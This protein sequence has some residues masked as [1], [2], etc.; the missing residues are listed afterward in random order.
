[1]NRLIIIGNGFDLAHGIKTSFNH[2]ISDYFCKAISSFF[3]NGLYSDTLLEIKYRQVSGYYDPK[4][5]PVTTENIYEIA[6]KL[7][8]SRYVDFNFKSILLNKV[9]SKTSV[10]RWVDIEV[11]F[12]NVLV[13]TKRVYSREK[14]EGAV[15]QVNE[16]LEYLKV[17]LIEYLTEQQNKFNNT[18]IK[19]PLANCFREEIKK[20]EIV[21]VNLEE[22]KLPDNLY[23]LN[24]NYTK[25]FEDYFKI[26]QRHIPSSYNYI[27]GSLS[28][29]HG[30]PIFGF[31]D[32]FDEKYLE[33]ENEKN[34][35]LFK[36][37][38]SFEY[39]QTKNFYELTRFLESNIFQ[40]HI[41]GH[42]FGISDR[43]MLNQIFEHNNCVSIKIFYHQKDEGVNDFTDKTYEISRHFKDKTMLRKK[44]APLELSTPMPQPKFS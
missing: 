2:F 12:F 35:A 9:Y 7:L 33:F 28:G 8:K 19:S 5:E 26:C 21:T 31:G 4:P 43:T 32:E 10:L 40:I 41:Y 38:K 14:V 37:I 39:L 20:D 30:N 15:E 27:H 6:N 11:E 17:E 16:Q 1:M 29:E 3:E 13:S 23:F 25:T 18:S 44:L 42:S 24:F 34:N 22:D 36:H